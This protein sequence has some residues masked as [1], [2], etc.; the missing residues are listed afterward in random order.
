MPEQ[1][2]KQLALACVFW[3]CLMGGAQAQPQNITF[4]SAD[5]ARD[6]F[7]EFK[8]LSASRSKIN[9]PGKQSV[10]L[11]QSHWDGLQAAWNSSEDDAE[12]RQKFT[13]DDDAFSKA[14]AEFDVAIKLVENAATTSQFDDIRDLNWEIH[15]KLVIANKRLDAIKSAFRQLDTNALETLIEDSNSDLDDFAR[16]MVARGP[17]YASN[18]AAAATKM[19]ADPITTTV[20]APVQETDAGD[21]NS[22]DTNNTDPVALV[23][24]NTLKFTPAPTGGPAI[25]VDLAQYKNLHIVVSANHKGTE[26]RIPYTV[27]KDE[28]ESEMNVEGA[29][30]INRDSYSKFDFNSGGGLRESGELQYTGID[31][32]GT[33]GCYL[34]PESLS[35]AGTVFTYQHRESRIERDALETLECFI[36]IA[37][38]I[39]PDGQTLQSL[40]LNFR[41]HHFFWPN[42]YEPSRNDYVPFNWDHLRGYQMGYRI[43]NLSLSQSLTDERTDCLVF[44]APGNVASDH[45]AISAEPTHWQKRFVSG[46]RVVFDETSVEYYL[47]TTW[48]DHAEYNIKSEIKVLLCKD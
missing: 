43:Q 39:A 14:K 36:D 18:I 23:D 17:G 40:R 27:S 26:Q 10:K 1:F 37:G 48:E 7:T 19:S 46:S 2:A 28:S 22:P 38:V 34:F 16:F 35:W 3:L 44:H 4:T 33:S 42:S 6:Y 11:L 47:G 24:I 5:Q 12:I 31:E 32:I 25:D 15:R 20:T 30:N 41:G 8:T 9:A 29:M 45:I 21:G 13:I